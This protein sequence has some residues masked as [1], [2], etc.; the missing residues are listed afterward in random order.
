MHLTR[1]STPKVSMAEGRRTNGYVICTIAPTPR[2]KKRGGERSRRKKHKERAAAAKEEARDARAAA[3]RRGEAPGL[4]A[5]INT[6]LGVCV[7]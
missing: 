5:F 2:R 7:K 4:F 3:D 1:C 6:Q